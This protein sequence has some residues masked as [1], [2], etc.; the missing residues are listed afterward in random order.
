MSK[1]CVK[2]AQWHIA[3][4]GRSR[5]CLHAANGPRHGGGGHICRA[6]A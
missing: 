1:Q 2:Y 4:T 3:A 5:D 6:L